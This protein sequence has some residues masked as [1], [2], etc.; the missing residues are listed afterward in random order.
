MTVGYSLVAISIGNLIFPNLYLIVRA[1][2]PDLK[3]AVIEM[4]RSWCCLKENEVE[5]DNRDIFEKKRLELIAHYNL[6]LKEEFKK[7]DDHE[8]DETSDE[9]ETD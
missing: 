6:V 5:N 7:H 9:E 3:E 4:V 8:E 1:I 2:W